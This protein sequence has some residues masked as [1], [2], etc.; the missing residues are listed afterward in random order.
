MKIS[1]KIKNR[2]LI[3]SYILFIVQVLFTIPLL[4]G[5]KNHFDLTIDDFRRLATCHVFSRFF[6]EYIMV[7]QYNYIAQFTCLPIAI[8][9][10]IGFNKGKNLFIK[11]IFTIVIVYEL[12]VFLVQGIVGT[13]FLGGPSN[14]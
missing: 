12:M 4:S 11:F 5:S 7:E 14:F 6:L 2:V 9:L 1:D 10:I 8:G 3:I 13:L